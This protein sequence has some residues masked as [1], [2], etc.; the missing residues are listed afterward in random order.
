M[1]ARV[2]HPHRPGVGRHT[3]AGIAVEKR[4]RRHYR[5]LN[6][7][8][9]PGEPRI[10]GGI[11]GAGT[12]QHGGD[13]SLVRSPSVPNGLIGVGLDSHRGRIGNP[14]NRLTV[15]TAETPGFRIDRVETQ[16]RTPTTAPAR[17]ALGVNTGG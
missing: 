4:I 6:R 10:S 12:K 11:H 3:G 9:R 1:T 15:A 16:K 5:G 8:A 17:V 14:V 2:R 13:W 7:D